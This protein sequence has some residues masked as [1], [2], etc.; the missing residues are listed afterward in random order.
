MRGLYI[1]VEGP[2][3]ETTVNEVLRPHLTQHGF[4]FV[5]ARLV[6]D[7]R[8]SS[9]GIVSWQVA[10]REIIRRLRGRGDPYVTT[11]VDYYGLPQSNGGAWPGRSA[12][13]ALPFAQR[14]STVENGM[15]A[16]IV[17][18]MG[19]DGFYPNRFIPFVVMHEFE[20]LLFS[21]CARFS[22]GIERPDLE[23]SF[24]KI[25]DTFDSPEE[26][27]DSPTHAPSKRILQLMPDYQKPLFGNLAVL[28]IGL[29]RIRHECHHFHAWLERIEAAGSV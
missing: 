5:A 15:M 11:L 3:E 9:G 19:G 24:Q 20:G 23:S 6:G 7:P 25:R 10:K 1:H 12:A 4:D 16:D 22:I 13:T 8:K 17:A 26:I 29:E 2:T 27:N 28:E 14:A 21:D 18:A